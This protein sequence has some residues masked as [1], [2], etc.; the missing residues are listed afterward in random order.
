VERPRGLDDLYAEPEQQSRMD[1]DGRARVLVPVAAARL[2]PSACFARCPAPAAAPA[3]LSPD[4]YR[5]GTIMR[6][7]A[8]CGASA[9]TPTASLTWRWPRMR[10]GCSR[11]RWTAACACGTSL[12]RSACR[13]AP[14]RPAQWSDL[15]HLRMLPASV[16]PKEK[17]GALFSR[18]PGR[19]LPQQ[20]SRCLAPA[21]K[22][23]DGFHVLPAP[24]AAPLRAGPCPVWPPPSSSSACLG[25]PSR[26]APTPS[27][28][29]SCRETGAA[30]GRARACAVPVTDCPPAGRTGSPL[31]TPWVINP[32]RG[33]CRCC[34]WARR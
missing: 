31:I 21:S 27:L 25:R 11:P 22:C 13:R 26:L 34:A 30:P 20:R 2:P 18:A 14:G 32:S 12:L 9:G 8:W 24:C 6:R 3:R 7:R 16:L 23:L 15:E 19:G 28:K 10:A 17:P 29:P 1:R 4:P 33:P 5:P